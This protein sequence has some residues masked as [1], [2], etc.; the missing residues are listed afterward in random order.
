MRRVN[1]SPLIAMVYRQ[2]KR[3]FSARSRLVSTVL[4][5]LVW[6]I[7][8]GL[9]WGSVFSASGFGGALPGIPMPPG[10]SISDLIQKYFNT[11]FGGVDYLTFMVSGMAS[12]AV[13]M[14]SFIGGISVIWDKQ[15][16]YLK[17]T[18]VAP[19]SRK[20]VIA[21]RILG[22][23]IVTTIQG[24]IIILLGFIIASGLRIA[25]V[26]IALI[27]LFFLAITFSSLGVVIALKLS[28]VE[29]FQMIVNLL[30]M[31]L[32]FVSGV[33]Y[34]FATM[35]SWMQ[36]IA[37]YNPL[38]YAVHAVRYWLTGADVGL[39]PMTPVNDLLVLIAGAAILLL[40]AGFAFE[41]TSIEE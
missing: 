36:V 24:L 8:L 35:P 19:A 9:G 40:M 39:S 12:M 28:S 38:S 30:T 18:L 32:M 27:Y 16:G 26:G 13:F 6:I 22:D 17:E 29:G 15:F 31:P 7:F 33:F 23:A 3:W 4:N 10:F 11:I 41:K 1:L 5:P 37:L 20:L 14:A 25:G 2:V 34:P 21:G